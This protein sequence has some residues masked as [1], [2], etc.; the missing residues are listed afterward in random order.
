MKKYLALI[1]FLLIVL[2]AGCANPPDAP[3]ITGVTDGHVY[4]SAVSIDVEPQDQVE[5]SAVIDEEPYTL[6]SAYSVEGVH[7]VQITATHIRSRL[8]SES[9]VRFEIDTMPPVT[10]VVDGV[11]EGDIIFQSVAIGI[12]EER[13]VAYD[14]A[15]DG[16]PYEIGTPYTE[17]GDHVLTVTARK[18]KNGL[19]AMREIHFTIENETYTQVEVDYFMEI[20]LGTEYGGAAPISKWTGN[21]RIMAHGD[22][23][24]EDMTN[25]NQVVAELRTLTGLDIGI[26]GEDAD[27]DI[28]YIPC[29]DFKQ[30]IPSYVE[31]NW[32]Y[33]SYNTR[34]DGEI[35][36]AVIGIDTILTN[37]PARNHLLREELTQSL[38]LGNDSYDYEDSMFYQGWTLTQSYSDIDRTVIELLYRDYIQIG[39]NKE[40]I[41]AVLAPRIAEN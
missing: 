25:L 30:Y 12:R 3:V 14:A 37:Q 17:A 7:T 21:I 41:R 23:T 33:F 29:T 22:P 15:I 31:G 26:V 4:A 9:T 27:I 36:Q 40:D 28:Y 2:L 1:P 38:G 39:M 10:P 24:E 13:G 6:G 19:T 34:G 20:A 8:T 32:G 18:N 16:R 5:Y 11:A 35:W